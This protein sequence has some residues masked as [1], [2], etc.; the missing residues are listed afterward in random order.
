MFSRSTEGR[1]ESIFSL[2]HSDIWGPSRA[3][4]TLGF[5]YFVNFIDDYSRCTWVF[6]MKDR[7]E[8]FSIFKSFFAEIQNQF[9]VSIRTFHS[10][11]ALEYLSS[12]YR[13]FMTHQGIIHQTTCPY[14]SQQNGVA[15]RK[16]RHL[17]ETARTLL[18]ESNVPLRFWGDEV[19]TSCCLINK[20]PS[21][22]I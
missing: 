8:L 20:M 5:H 3:S 1:S 11:N 13:E 6:L 4:S 2:V 16:N 14:T 19:L 10:D 17:I 15:E 12:Q 9:G 18:L 21:S 7:S 22:S